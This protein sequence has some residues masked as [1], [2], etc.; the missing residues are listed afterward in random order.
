MQSLGFIIV[1]CRTELIP[2]VRYIYRR[3]FGIQKIYEKSCHRRSAL[4]RKKIPP[5]NFMPFWKLM[6][7]RFLRSFPTGQ[8]ARLKIWDARLSAI[9][10][11]DCQS[12][13]F[14]K[15]YKSQI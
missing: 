5:K 14:E 1:L 6:K 8:F 10:I 12:K 13:T 2:S 4:C 3:V 15:L 9:E 7:F 11:Y